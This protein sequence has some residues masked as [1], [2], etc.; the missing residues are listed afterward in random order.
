MAK[1]L[2][3]TGLTYLW[4]KI[5]AAFQS[6][7]S[8]SG[9][10]K[11]DGSGGVTAAVSGTD[12]QAPL[13]SQTGNSG[14]FLTT[15]GSAMS[16]ATVSAGTSDI[17]WITVTAD[18]S[19]QTIVYSAD[20]TYAEITAAKTAGQ[21]PVVLYNDNTYYMSSQPS[22]SMS[23]TAYAFIHTQ[24]YTNSDSI[25]PGINIKTLEVTSND[26]WNFTTGDSADV[27]IAA[28]DSTTFAQV[29]AAY[30]ASKQIYVTDTNTCSIYVPLVQYYDGGGTAA[31]S[32]F[33][34]VALCDSLSN[35]GLYLKYVSI[36]LDYDDNWTKVYDELPYAPLASP[37]FT[38][39]PTA[40]TATSGTNTTQI[41]TT[42]FVQDAVSGNYYDA[43]YGT[44]SYSDID[45]Q[46]TAGDKVIRLLH[47]DEYL[48]F[49][50]KLTNFNID[51]YDCYV[52][53]NERK[54]AAINSANNWFHSY[55]Y[56]NNFV[57]LAIIGEGGVASQV[58]TTNTILPRLRI[59]SALRFG[60]FITECTCFDAISMEGV[61]YPYESVATRIYTF[62]GSN[63]DPDPNEPEAPTEYYFRCFDGNSYRQI[64]LT[65]TVG[66]EDAWTMSRSTGNL[67]PQTVTSTIT[68][69]NWNSSTLQCTKT[70]N[71]IAS[72]S[73]VQV[74]PAP[75]SIDVAAAAGVYCSAQGTGSLTFTCKKIPT[76]NITM[77]VMYW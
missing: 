58:E 47:G 16:W 20:K 7:V 4:G 57:S 68:V 75:S 77:N 10:L 6:K 36:T 62:C 13:P 3:S 5:T 45:T 24:Y 67:K 17:F 50:R 64:T 53:K 40:P 42:A 12:Y 39:T 55:V 2:D 30:N 34:F 14:K 38:G 56:D 23:R 61:G 60:V 32:L 65:Q 43:V 31:D 22:G 15:N 74:S 72:D 18:T 28:Y 66:P 52:F 33:K 11:G 26:T 69:A 73:T 63:A 1:Y 76:A 46:Y 29:L 9:I 27:F 49:F 48:Y 25:V 70:V 71:G 8:A 54:I 35:S 19:G 44:T 59:L 21:F 41:A 37:A 51:E